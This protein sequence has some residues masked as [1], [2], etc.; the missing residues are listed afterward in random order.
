MPTKQ[1]PDPAAERWHLRTQADVARAFDVE[2]STVHGWIEK[3]MPGRPGAYDCR[4][5]T[6]WLLSV[7]PWRSQRYVDA[8]I[9]NAITRN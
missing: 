1:Q 6:R 3:G 2:R 9:E 7:G 5:I 8:L 4:H